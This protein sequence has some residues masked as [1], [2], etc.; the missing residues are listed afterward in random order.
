MTNL[1]EDLTRFT[2]YELE[3][4]K[5]EMKEEMFNKIRGITAFWNESDEIAYMTFYYNGEVEKNDIEA[6]SEICTYIIS[7]LIKGSLNEKYKRL[8]YPNPLP[9]NDF[10]VYK[11][12]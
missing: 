6:P 7:H 11:K 5:L 9:D 12:E 1:Q 4:A 3:L 2:V 8:D 10:W